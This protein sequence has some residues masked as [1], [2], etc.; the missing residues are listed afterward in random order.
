MKTDRRNDANF[1]V[2]G[3]TITYYAGNFQYHQWLLN[4]LWELWVFS[5][6]VEIVYVDFVRKPFEIF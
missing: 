3:G 4:I 5:A 2:T 6:S 1:V